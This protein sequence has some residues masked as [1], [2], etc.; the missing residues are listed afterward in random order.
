AIPV[1]AQGTQPVPQPPSPLELVRGIREAGMPDL[2]LEYLRDIENK[3]LSDNDKQA[4]LLERARCL[5]DTAD[6]EPDEGTRAS[7]IGEAKEAFNEFLV[8]HANHPRASEASLALARLTS[9]EAKAQLNRARR[10]DIP[11]PPA[12]D[13]SDK[14]EKERERDAAIDKQRNEAK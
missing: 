9:L 2:A 14:A 4:I 7:M 11:P 8:K 3:P 6:A 10:M 12:A 5:L 1:L 13:A